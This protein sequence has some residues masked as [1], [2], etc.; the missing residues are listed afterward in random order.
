MT[1]RKR[2]GPLTRP[3]K[4]RGPEL[5]AASDE[6]KVHK[7]ARSRGA[8]LWRFL[9]LLVLTMFPVLRAPKLWLA[10]WLSERP[11]A[12]DG[13]GHFG[14]A[15]VYDQSIF[16]DT[17]GWTHAYFAG[18]PLPNFYPPLFYWLVAL[19]HHTHLFS[20]PAAFKLVLATPVL[21][22]PA[23]MWTLG[24][25]VFDRNRLAAA[26]VAF[27]ALPQ[28]VD[29][30]F[31][32]PV[33]LNNAGTFLIG[34]Y[35]QPLGFVLL[36]AWLVVYL[37]AD[38][39]RRRFALASVLLAL[40]VLAN[41]FNAVTAALF[42]A[43]VLLSD[44]VKLYRGAGP[45]SRR[46][47]LRALLGHSASPVV[48]ALLSAFWLAPLASQY[49]YF[50]TRPNT[51][52]LAELVPPVM[53]AWYALASVGCW[54]WLRRPTRAMWPYLLACLALACSVAFAA[55]IAPRWFPL[56]SVRFLSTLNF[57]LAVP[58]G[59]ALLS[60]YEFVSLTFSRAF[61]AN[62]SR[63][64]S[65]QAQAAVAGLK[66]SPVTLVLALALLAA[67]FLLIKPP[68]YT[69]AFLP[70]EGS[71]LIDP[72][73]NFAR[74]QRDG[75]Y[76]VEVPNFDFGAAALD[77][78]ALNSYLGAQG[79]ETASVVFREASPNA[80]F[81]NPLVTAFSAF[82]DNFGVSS[83]LADDLDFIQQPLERHLERAR[84]M[85]VRYLVIVS[86]EVKSRLAREPGVGQR[87]EL[88]PWT[89]FELTGEQIPKVRA[90]AYRPALVVSNF[91]LK[92][93]RR[94]ELDFVRLC[95]EQ[96][97][98]GWHD[99]LL[100]RAPETRIDR[101]KQLDEF[102]ALV[103]DVYEYVDEDAAFERLREYA[104]R[105]ALVLLSSEAPLFRR[106][107]SR[108]GEFPSATVVERPLEEPGERLRFDVPT[109]RY[110]GS[111]LR[112]M[113]GE[114]R[115]ALESRKVAVGAAPV[116]NGEVKGRV[117]QVDFAAPASEGVPVLVATT[118]HPGW[119]RRDGSAVY[120]A[121]PFFMLSF[122]R[123]SAQLVY[124]RSRLDQVGALVSACTVVLLCGFSFYQAY[125]R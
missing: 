82:P 119:Q 71:A 40:T 73:L 100:A 11:R 107:R 115:R 39:G 102:G 103:L 22:I 116:L 78:R 13:T 120:V 94:N 60:G 117:I 79:N 72:V 121:S 113:W 42:V 9:P 118:Y 4:R 75:R 30:R 65:G 104:Q 34:L 99:V 46:D 15:Q 8:G 109:F 70:R 124:E 88:G 110:D 20:L 2:G 21:L 49:D 114:I 93:R 57:L 112:K 47:S 85:G 74:Q 54:L 25:A 29:Y 95:E 32:H 80:L 5:K 7:P 59:R 63:P 27:A 105:R 122:F 108:I 77:G 19:L 61:A 6:G 69:L 38:W 45:G 35:T 14:V 16:P 3:L 106:I 81:L 1:S 52:P 96:F 12:W 18:M 23:A 64:G 36:I 62:R 90:L 92:E 43:A 28:L 89:V 98:D 101:I 26:A 53:L 44:A 91:T 111:A 76:L 123:E 58:V 83:V 66:Y 67:A 87:Q 10:L 24:W 56:Q 48:A 41:F 86:P 68:A 50:V 51:F 33:G 17:F 37:G 31:Y 55:V 125:R 84:F 97:A